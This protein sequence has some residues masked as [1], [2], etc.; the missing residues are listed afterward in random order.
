[1][2][3]KGLEASHLDCFNK[4]N[5]KYFQSNFKISP[6]APPKTTQTKIKLK[7]KQTN[8]KTKKG[9]LAVSI[10]FLSLVFNS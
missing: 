3:Y 10:F 7:Q 9:K 1:M 2:P 5:F 4:Q 6:F 8:K